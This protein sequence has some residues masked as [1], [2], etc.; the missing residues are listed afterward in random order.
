M[1]SLMVPAKTDELQK[2]LDFIE[3][4]LRGQDCPM[5]TELQIMIAVEEVFV[6]IAHYA[7]GG[8]PGMVVISYEVLA[9]PPSVR[10][11]FRD[12]GEPYNPLE[13]EDP[14]VSRPAEERDIGGLGIFMVKKSMDRLEYAYEDGKN[15]LTLTKGW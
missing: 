1:K 4:E 7:Y 9:D 14:D 2:V 11:Q 15:V 3:G 12:D 13:R 5:K 6:N 8:E 10:I